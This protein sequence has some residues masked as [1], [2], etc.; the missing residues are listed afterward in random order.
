MVRNMTL[1]FVLGLM[2]VSPA[3]ASERPD[4]SETE[5]RRLIDLT[6][7]ANHFRL[8]AASQ[9]EDVKLSGVDVFGEKWA[10]ETW[11][12]L[13]GL[14]LQVSHFFSTSLMMVGRVASDKSVVGFYNPWVDG[15]LLTAWSERAVDGWRIAD[16]AWLTGE[17]FRLDEAPKGAAA[18]V[19]AWLHTGR[20]LAPSVVELSGKTIERFEKLFPLQAQ[21]EFPLLKVPDTPEAELALIKGRM[22]FRLVY[23]KEKLAGP[24]GESVRA[25]VE[26]VKRVLLSGDKNRL[27]ALTSPEQNAYVAETIGLLPEQIR[28]TMNDHWCVVNDKQAVAVL[29]SS[30]A[31]RWFLL[32]FL[33]FDQADHPLRAVNLY[34]FE[35]M[36]QGV[37]G[38]EESR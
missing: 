10:R 36:R 22:T 21:Y 7:S 28:R 1:A 26:N 34:D 15:L 18:I 31:P 5:I 25:H 12:Q 37:Q 29:T 20:G 30:L 17:T 35:A 4:L 38:K 24:L 23:A 8:G 16:F 3:Q 2:A 27:L 33:N 19:P 6:A 9:P 13:K 14:D 11:G 32:V